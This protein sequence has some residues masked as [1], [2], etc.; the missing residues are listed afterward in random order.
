MNSDRNNT[1]IEK[2]HNIINYFSHDIRRPI[3][4]IVGI[5]SCMQ[6]EE[7]TSNE[8]TEY[9]KNLD[10]LLRDLDDALINMESKLLDAHIKQ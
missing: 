2:P 10:Q 8:M 1:E 9:K 7:C 6:K 4:N 5:A 3:A